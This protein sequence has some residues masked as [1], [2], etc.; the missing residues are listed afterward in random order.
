[1]EEKKKSSATKAKNKYKSKTYDRIEL[2]VPKGKKDLIKA[3]ANEYQPA[4][5]EKGVIGYTPKGSISGFINRAIDETMKND[6]AE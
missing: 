1:M 4:T 5:G 2:I 3:H 6:I